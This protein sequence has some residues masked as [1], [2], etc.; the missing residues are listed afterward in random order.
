MI[1]PMLEKLKPHLILAAAFFLLILGQQYIFFLIKELKLPVFS[2]HKYLFFYLLLLSFTFIKGPKTRWFFLSILMI[3]VFPQMGHYSYY[4]TPVAA[5]EIWLGLQVHEIGGVLA[6]ETHHVVV[7]IIMVI[8]PVLI[9]SFVQ[10]KVKPNFQYKTVTLLAGMLVIFFPLRTYTSGNEWGKIPSD[11]EPMSINMFASASYFVGRILPHKIGGGILPSGP[12][13]SIYLKFSDA[14]TSEWDKVVV[15]M[16]ESLSTRH[17][18]L[19]GYALPTTPFLDT[20]KSDPNFFYTTGISSGVNTDVSVSFFLNLAFGSPGKLKCTIGDHCIF[21]LAKGNGFSTH[22][23]SIQS[24]E[25]LKY[26]APYLCFSYIDTYKP[27]EYVSPQTKNHM[28]AND[29]DLLPVFKD[30]LERNSKDFVVL[31]QRGSHGPWGLRSFPD[32]KIFKAENEKKQPVADYDNSVF[33]F[34]L[35]MRDLMKTIKSTKK[36]TLV[37]YLSDHG[38]AIGENNRWGHGF[39][40]PES[41]EIP[42]LISSVNK[43]LPQ[44]LKNLPP[45]LTQ[46]GLGLFMTEQLGLIAN[47]KSSEQVKDF[48]IYGNDIDGFAGSATLSFPQAG[49]YEVTV[50]P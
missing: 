39:L 30:V 29:R 25:Q 2:W 37:I 4:A 16:G 3:I 50:K 12:N 6:Q 8:I 45:V 11:N 47:Q 26:I 40:V 35:F 5:S 13:S 38:E 14:K 19:F 20:L 49:K 32:S 24:Q 34:D 9:G 15:V 48:M 31:H 22:F 18:S 36:K 43:A 42:M 21:K 1:N 41:Y 7:A 33:E 28:A 10:W 27:L 23:L 17:M 46:Y 44:A